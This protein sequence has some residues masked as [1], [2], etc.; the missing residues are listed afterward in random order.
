[1]FQG[2]Q[3]FDR[4]DQQFTLTID[5]YGRLWLN[6][7]LE[8]IEISLDL[9]EKTTAFEIMAETMARNDFEYRP[10]QAHEV[11]DNDDEKPKR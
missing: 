3:D 8:G 10:I 6:T 4:K 9:A 7:K 11:A 5:Q 2:E 1:M